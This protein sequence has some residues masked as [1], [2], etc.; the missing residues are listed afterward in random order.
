MDQQSYSEENGQISAD[1]LLAGGQ[2][3]DQWIAYRAQL[4]RA[5]DTAPLLEMTIQSSATLIKGEKI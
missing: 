3:N 2:Q 4:E 5:L 1:N